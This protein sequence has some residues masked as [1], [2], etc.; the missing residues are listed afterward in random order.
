MTPTKKN[1]DARRG[2][3][4]VGAMEKTIERDLVHKRQALSQDMEPGLA[5]PA[6]GSGRVSKRVGTRKEG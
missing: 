1:S 2:S 3:G 4:A 5:V 6:A